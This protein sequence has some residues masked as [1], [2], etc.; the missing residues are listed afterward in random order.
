MDIKEYRKAAGISQVKLC[1]ELGIPKRT[2]EYWEGG[3]RTPSPY[4]VYL[5]CYWMAAEYGLEKPE[6]IKK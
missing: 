1:E 3:G 6:K 5:I 4:L 2:L